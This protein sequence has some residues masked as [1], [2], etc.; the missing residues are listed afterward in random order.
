MSAERTTKEILEEKLAGGERVPLYNP[1]A[2]KVIEKELEEWKNKTVRE[3]DRKNWE[4]TPHT[5]LG[6]GIPRR[7][8]YTPLDIANIDYMKDIGLPGGEPFT[9]GI[10]ANMYRGR[11]FTMRPLP[12][13]GTTEEM[14]RKWKFLIEQG[15]TGLSVALDLPTVQMFDSDEPEAKGHVA[16]VGVPLCCVDDWEVAF[17]DIPIDK[18]SY[19]IVTHFP[20]NTAILLPMY[21][22][23]A[24]RR[25]IP[26]DKLTGSVQ[27][28]IV[29]E[30][31]VRGAIEYIPPEDC[32]RV[33]CDN[34]EF[35]RKEVPQWNYI[36]LN[37]YNLREYGTTG[38]TEMAV[39]MANGI[40]I[41][42]EMMNRG[43]DADWVGERIAFFWAFANDFFEEVAKNRAA[44]RLW[45]K[46]MKYRFGAKNPRSM[47]LRTH[48]QTSGASLTREEPINNIIRAAYHAMASILTGTQSLHVSCFDEA[49]SVPSEKTLLPSVRTQQLIEQ[50]TQVTQVVDPLAG[51][52]FVEWITNEM[53]RK[54]LDELDEIEKMGGIAKAIASGRLHHKIAEHIERENRAI[55]SGEISVVGRNVYKSEEPE[56]QIEVSAYQPEVYEQRKAMLQ[57][58]RDTRDNEKASSCLRALVDACKRGKNVTYFTLECARANVTEGEMRKAFTEA[59]GTWKPPFML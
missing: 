35:I 56:P 26:W 21:L 22:V 49:F 47:W 25:G 36:T 16:V 4:I 27:N 23:M 31:L 54:V 50:E 40:S 17:K 48:V 6:S 39:A 52:F 19:S 30:N 3:K 33:Q 59:F 57:K 43:Y 20:R 34:I 45:Y 44:R 42:E 11:T 55:E 38:I 51:S 18:I 1:E 10:H 2:L 13:A 29:M 46:I 53:E 58:V 12:G 14:N 37:G 28:D 7:L 8:T 32:F 24:E 5:I 15:A 9:R 41:T